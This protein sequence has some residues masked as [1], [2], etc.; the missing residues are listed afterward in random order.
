MMHAWSSDGEFFED[1]DALARHLAVRID[2]GEDRVMFNR[3]GCWFR[4]SYTDV[5]SPA[6]MTPPVDSYW[7]N[8]TYTVDLVTNSPSCTGGNVFTSTWPN[9]YSHE[10]VHVVARNAS[11]DAPAIVDGTVRDLSRVLTSIG[12]VLWPEHYEV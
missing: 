11:S 5:E 12:I 2:S 4:L 1:E 6:T 8:R 3:E 9:G 7:R 10:P